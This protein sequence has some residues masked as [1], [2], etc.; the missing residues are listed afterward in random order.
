LTDRENFVLEQRVR[1]R[2]SLAATGKELLNLVYG[3]PGVSPE[4]VRQVEYKALRKLRYFTTVISKQEVRANIQNYLTRY[5][6]YLDER[7]EYVIEQMTIKHR[8]MEEVGKE[9]IKLSTKRMGVRKA[10]IWAIESGAIHRITVFANEDRKRGLLNDRNRAT[11]DGA[12]R[13]LR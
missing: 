10:T 1:Q 5:R 8:S 11:P 3:R 6:E 9:V 2:K 4:R 7:E 12:R 13:A